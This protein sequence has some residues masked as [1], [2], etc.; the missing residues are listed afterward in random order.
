M[1]RKV[2]ER[3]Q[4]WKLDHDGIRA[5]TAQKMADQHEQ[6]EDQAAEIS[7]N[8]VEAQEIICNEVADE[9]ALEDDS[10]H[11]VEANN[12]HLEGYVEDEGNLKTSTPFEEEDAHGNMDD[13]IAFANAVNSRLGTEI[14]RRRRELD[15]LFDSG[16]STGYSSGEDSDDLE[17]AEAEV[18]VE[19]EPLKREQEFPDMQ[20]RVLARD[21][22]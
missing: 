4:K 18:A 16:Y 12:S 1:F 3:L 22:K 11:P 8:T 5:N 7:G 10:K 6:S 14:L 2:L 21:R 15:V 9:D 17:I 13:R 20:V 19:V